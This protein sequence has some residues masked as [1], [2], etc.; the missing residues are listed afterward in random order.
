MH[1]LSQFGLFME[2][3]KDKSSINFYR[4]EYVE[5]A[6]L[7]FDGDFVCSNIPNPILKLKTYN[8][9]KE[10]PKGYWIGYGSLEDGKLKGVGKWVSKTSKKR[11]A[12][13]SQK[14]AVDNFIKRNE[15]KIKILKRQIVS[16]EIVVNMAKNII[17]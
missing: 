16:C 6:S 12:Y 13:P 3:N 9:W 4:Y 5:H 7:D 11:Y 14:E 10:T 8:L 15:R 1:Q 2:N 17:L